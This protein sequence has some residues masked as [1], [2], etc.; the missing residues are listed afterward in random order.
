MIECSECRATIHYQ[1]TELPLYMIIS[2]V[3]GR[4]KYSCTFCRNVIETLEKYIETL[5][6]DKPSGNDASDTIAEKEMENL[7]LLFSQKE[8]EIEKLDRSKTVNEK[9]IADMKLETENLKSEKQVQSNL[10]KLKK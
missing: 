3:K 10:I 7:K 1:C 6:T 8:I 2:L 5:E 9:I 4:R